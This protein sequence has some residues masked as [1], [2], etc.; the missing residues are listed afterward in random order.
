MG[1]TELPF[2]QC[3]QGIEW[4]SRRKG[5][6]VLSRPFL[7][8]PHSISAN[9][10]N[11]HTISFQRRFR[12]VDG[13]HGNWP[14]STGLGTMSISTPLGTVASA[15]L[16]SQ[17]PSLPSGSRANGRALVGATDT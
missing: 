2:G 13:C 9:I 12:P 17:S 16:E 10:L 7:L 8:E 4:A 6:G 3:L 15:A 14:V 5:F 11:K 1:F